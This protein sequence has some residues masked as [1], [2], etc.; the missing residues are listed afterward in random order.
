MQDVA[1]TRT[2]KYGGS[3]ENRARFMIK[4]TEAVTQAVGDKRVGIRFSPWSKG[5]GKP[6]VLSNMIRKYSS[7]YMCN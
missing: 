2:D 3:I 1:N 4:V 5:Q 7:S 6:S